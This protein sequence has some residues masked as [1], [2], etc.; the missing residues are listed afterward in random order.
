MSDHGTEYDNF[1][2]DEPRIDDRLAI[3]DER[4]RK[5][6]KEE[7]G[8]VKNGGYGDNLCGN[9]RFLEGALCQIV[10]GAI[11]PSDIC[12]LYEPI[13][14]SGHMNAGLATLPS[15][16][17]RRTM[18][19]NRVSENKQTGKK[20]W[21][22]TASGINYD[23]YKDRMSVELFQDF[24][25]KIEA[26]TK[27]PELF[28]TSYF[29][30]GLPYL[31]V[32]H[33]QDL[34]GKGVAG[35]SE[36]IWVD[37]N[38][39]KGKGEFANTPLGDAVHAAIEKD[40]AKNVP[41]D[42]RIRIS[43]AFL[44]YGHEHEGE[45]IF[46]RK[47]LTDQ[48]PMCVDGVGEKIYRQGQ[49]IHLAATRVPAY[50]ET[51]MALTERA[52]STRLDD[53]E[54]IIG[55]DLAS[56]LED[57]SKAMIGRSEADDESLQAVTVIKSESDDDSG[58]GDETSS[59]QKSKPSSE[60]VEK[61][62]K[63]MKKD[64]DDEEEE[65]DD[66]KELA[67]VQT[68]LQS[69]AGAKSI[70]EAE[71]FLEANPLKEPP[72]HAEVFSSVL[73]NIVG[74]DEVATKAI[75][76]VV[77]EYNQGLDILTLETLMDVRN[78]LTGGI[79]VMTEETKQEKTKKDETATEEIVTEDTPHILRSHFDAFAQQFDDAMAT[80]LT[81]IERLK[82]LQE[83][84]NELAARVQ[85]TVNGEPAAD[86]MPAEAIQRAVAEAMAPITNQLNVVLAQLGT[87]TATPITTSP[88]RRAVTPKPTLVIERDSGETSL[89]PMAPGYKKGSVKDIIRRSTGIA[90]PQQYY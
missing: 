49:L 88:A 59:K 11:E 30:G 13:R 17:V 1:I 24:I 69:Y 54:S 21:F 44:D 72:H 45:G 80:P 85:K 64:K 62:K 10:E 3:V 52:M 50:K 36:K 61:Q 66:E 82:M 8:F 34:D 78:K 89:S 43:I 53:A 27:L 75:K 35:T 31:S 48:C 19:I 16:T 67:K 87:R 15:T 83:P 26:R 77:D 46:E 51:S 28:S 9:C 41:Q 81:N 73:A 2:D 74:A 39:F 32:A 58:E 18:F 23:E 12:N 71:Q 14:S 86:E 60:L 79:N 55:K 76:S 70:G 29:N 20:Y 4:G 84:L 65:E 5:Y 90:P 57:K 25:Q 56:E 68:S 63:H 22:A 37:G 38:I 47:K 33:Y 42:E 40:I 7:S 6:S